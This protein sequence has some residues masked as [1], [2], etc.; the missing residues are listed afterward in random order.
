MNGAAEALLD[1]LITINKEQADYLKNIAARSGGTGGSGSG[2]GEVVKQGNMLTGIFSA[3]G[4]TVSVAASILG[5]AFNVAM[6]LATTGFRGLTQAG[7]AL[8]QNQMRLSEGAIAGTNSLSDLTAGLEQLPFGLG[9]VA[10]AMTY[11]TKKLE[12]NIATFQQL[13]ETGTTLGGNLNQVRESAKGMYLSMDEFAKVMK[14]SAPVLRYLGS[15]ADEGAKNLIKF[16][17]GLVQGNVGKQLLSMGYTLEEVNGMLGTYA[18]V[19]GG[20]REGD[21]K[22]QKRM[23]QSVKT[24]AEE[25]D[26]S[27]QLEGKTRKQKEEEL[28]KAAAQAAVEAKLAGMTQEQKDK[29]AQAL[30]AA[31]REG[32]GAVDA[33][34]SEMLGFPPMTKAAQMYTAVVGDGAAAQR[35][36][37][38]LV[39]DNS[40]AAEAR[41]RIDRNAAAAT[42]ANIRAYEQGG[43]ALQAATF[44]NGALADQAQQTARSVADSRNKN[45]RNEEDALKRIN[46]TRA[47][48]DQAQQSQIGATVQAQGA[49]KHLGGLMDM[50]SEALK[51]L[52]PVVHSLVKGFVEILPKVISFGSDVITKIIIPLFQDL[53]GGLT[54]DDVLGPFKDFFKGLFGSGEGATTME[55]VRKGLSDF[56]KPITT[57]IGDIIKAIDWQAVGAIFRTTF[58]TIGNVIKGL[59]DIIGKIFGGDG[60]EF[61]KG[62]Q[63]AFERFSSIINR[64]VE[65][66]QG[67]VDAAASTPLF[68]N[69]KKFFLKLFDVA[70]SIV[71]VLLGI[72]ESPI[73]KFVIAVLGTAANALFEV[74]NAVLDAVMGVV[75]I[76]DFVGS[77]LSG[78]LSILGDAVT[79]ILFL[80]SEMVKGIWE[81]F[82]SLDDM[83]SN[84]LSAAWEMVVGAVSGMINAV[85]NGFIAI[86]DGIVN[87]ING[88][89]ET[90]L[91]DIWESV[92]SIFSSIVDSVKNIGSDLISK[93]TSWGSDEEEK[94]EPTPRPQ[95]APA[96][97]RQPATREPPRPPARETTATA[98]PTAAPTPGSPADIAQI[99]RTLPPMTAASGPGGASADTATLNTNLQ[100]MIR[101]LREI[102]DNTKRTADL[103]AS[104]GNLFR[105]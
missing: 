82:T 43:A 92:K 19:V 86:K 85:V 69:M 13:S 4:R 39:N 8:W 74:F 59:A 14:E 55:S 63:S 90:F 65:V 41:S 64:I 45:I 27:A 40:T 97:P 84:L 72:I 98:N 76:V 49:V 77:I 21:L 73:G 28:K 31:Q 80:V 62:L 54:L 56:L 66:V 9:L 105:R 32:Q 22:N 44:S 25:L 88:G 26:L 87:F 29:Y 75:K 100:Q 71:E 102:S 20:V 52:F 16:N 53:F 23:E 46:D 89:Y 104:N 42:A 81:W 30:A 11:Q 33:L 83:I 24:F 91:S 79:Y 57:F 7:D 6:G 96:Q 61:G 101:N 36:N 37:A 50:L 67:I 95:P 38:Q 3:M 68:D 58:Q 5:G 94:P 35:R 47:A 34:H 48:Q 1:E 18:S 70:F 60:G 12:Q 78:A 93:I 2:G 15:T 10:Q 99:A 51:P 103:I 17:T